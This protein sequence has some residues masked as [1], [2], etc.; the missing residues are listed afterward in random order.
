MLRGE[1]VPPSLPSQW[2][3]LLDYLSSP[4]PLKKCAAP[5]SSIERSSGESD[6]PLSPSAKGL[7]NG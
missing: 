7:F 6:H 1:H 5:A 2:L 3:L 4:K